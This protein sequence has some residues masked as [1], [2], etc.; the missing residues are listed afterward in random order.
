MAIEPFA[1]AD[2]YEA[3]YG[4]VEEADRSRLKPMLLD[5]TTYI[6]ARIGYVPTHGEDEIFDNNAKAVCLSMVHRAFGRK[7]QGITQMSQTGGSYQKT[8]TYSNP[9]G[10]VYLT[11]QERELL[12]IDGGSIISVRQVTDGRRHHF[13]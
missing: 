11:K 10:D 13:W 4:I 7:T 6:I 2:D 8:L 1:T 5:A 12:G 9:D 3:R